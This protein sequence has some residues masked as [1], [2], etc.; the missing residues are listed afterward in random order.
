[1]LMTLLS[2][3]DIKPDRVEIS[4]RRSRLIEL[5]ESGSI[6]LVTQLS[7]AQQRG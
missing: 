4:V 3:V 6:D 2:R 5:L 7:D 1:M